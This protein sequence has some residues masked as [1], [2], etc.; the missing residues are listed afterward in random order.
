MLGLTALVIGALIGRLRGGHWSALVLAPVQG[1][2]FLIVGVA[3]TLVLAVLEPSFPM[4]W[5]TVSLLALLG[6]GFSNLAMSGV[7]V[8]MIGLGSNLLALLVNGAVPVSE[9]ALLSVGRLDDNGLALI[10]GAH[11]STATASRLTFLADVVPV[12]LFGAV[13]SLGDLIALV[14]VADIVANLLLRARRT[15]D[16]PKPATSGPAH[17]SSSRARFNLRL[18]RTSPAHA[19]DPELTEAEPQVIEPT[20]E[21]LRVVKAEVTK[22]RTDEDAEPTPAGASASTLGND[23]DRVAAP[24]PTVRAPHVPSSRRTEDD[25]VQLQRR[26]PT[27]PDPVDDPIDL[28]DRRPI[29]DLTV[30]PSDEQLAEFLRRRREADDRR[31][32]HDDDDHVRRRRRRRRMSGSR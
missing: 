32:H 28:T 7:I 8:F 24:N 20:R 17:A 11:E 14:G 22:P 27:L 15:V 10:S 29:I 31:L 19:V 4:L 3:A 6:F 26:R 25:T 13:V 23:S 12:P 9:R 18:F 2:A 16:A 21:K 1:Q 30:S 5:T